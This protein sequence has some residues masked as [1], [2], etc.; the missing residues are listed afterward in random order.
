M[1]LK[2][3]LACLLLAGCSDARCRSM[4]GPLAGLFCGAQGDD[5]PGPVAPPPAAC[6]DLTKQAPALFA[7][8]DDPAQ[9]LQAL[10]STLSQL[11]AVQC[12][13][14]SRPA[15]SSDLDCDGVAC[16]PD[17]KCAC[18]IAYN[19]LG[20]VLRAGLRGLG[21]ASR[22]P[23]ESATQQCLPA[24]D[25]ASLPQQN[26]L[27]ELKRAW[28]VLRSG[29]TGP[30]SDPRL[31]ATLREV[32][33]YTSGKTDGAVHAAMAGTFGRMAL[34][35]D[36]CD[37]AD[38]FSLLEKL[39]A[40][41]TPDNAAQATGVL[42]ALIE[43]PTLRPLLLSL[44]SGSSAEGRDSAVYLVHFFIDEIAAVQTGAQASA[45]LQDILDK[46]VYPQVSDAGLRAHIQAAVDLLSR[47][48]AD[49]V[50]AFPPLQRIIACASNPVVD[51]DP[52]S[53]KSSELIGAVYDLLVSPNGVSVA[54][55]LDLVTDLVKL[56][57][58]GQVT[59]AAHDLVAAMLGDDQA[60]DAVRGA[61]ADALC[62]PGPVCDGVAFSTGVLPALAVL[63][64]HGALLDLVTLLSDVLE[65]CNK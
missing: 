39:L 34:H 2:H 30:L 58:G 4:Q 56:D 41:L 55:E 59:R 8:I 48:I 26:H 47:M 18:R 1:R 19:P 49:D 15:C 63:S 20:E 16:A 57:T 5:A 45:A 3:A 10:R 6:A 9:P 25:A 37:P 40:H 22:E 50:G 36:L 7:L 53:G 64:D 23:P 46:Y 44:E 35:G 14:A 43:D 21:A 24:A 60:L 31:A 17:G 33:D 62:G 11:D 51:D 38:F 29:S 65:G 52:V 42:K 27:C 13:D 12:L 32:A 54:D 28:A 61:A